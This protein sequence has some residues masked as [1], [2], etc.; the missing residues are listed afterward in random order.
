MATTTEQKI[1]WNWLEYVSQLPLSSPSDA[2]WTVEVGV[3]RREDDHERKTGKD[4]E[5]H[6]HVHGLFIWKD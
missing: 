1:K 4:Y 5:H 2:I 3:L 6:G